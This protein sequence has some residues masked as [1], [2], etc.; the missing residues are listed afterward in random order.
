[1]VMCD[2]DEVILEEMRKPV[3]SS[4]GGVEG[5]GGAMAVSPAT[6]RLTLTCELGLIPKPTHR[7]LVTVQKCRGLS[8]NLP[9]NCFLNS[10]NVIYLAQD[11][12]LSVSCFTVK[13][14]YLF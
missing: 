12:F 2:V 11:F 5:K 4:W 3:P 1:M 14:K 7:Q 13:T 8:M 10:R 6:T 9:Q